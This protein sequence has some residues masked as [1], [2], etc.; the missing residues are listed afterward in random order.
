[1][2]SLRERG[3]IIM[4]QRHFG[5]AKVTNE[6]KPT[7]VHKCTCIFKYKFMNLDSVPKLNAWSTDVKTMRIFG[8]G[9]S[10]KGAIGNAQR[11]FLG[12]FNGKSHVKVEKTIVYKG[13]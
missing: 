5:F 11:K 10:W 1:M 7:T 4:T 8:I 6:A 12:I 3:E 9:K 2:K 13:R